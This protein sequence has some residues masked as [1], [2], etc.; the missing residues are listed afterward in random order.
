MELCVVCGRSRGLY[1]SASGETVLC[2]AHAG[3]AVV[4]LRRDRPE[5]PLVRPATTA[6]REAVL[7][8]TDAFWGEREVAAFGR[9]YDLAD[10]PAL[11]AVDGGRTVGSVSYALEGEV[12][13]LVSMQVLPRFQGRGLGRRLVEAVMEIGR[14]AEARRLQLVT[15]ND[16][17]PALALYQRLGLTITEVVPG[18]VLAHHGGHVE[19]GFAGIPVRDEIRMVCDL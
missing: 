17:L 14:Q 6:D 3:L 2:P 5:P 18:A 13:H 7:E 19:A 9:T 10:L 4:P 16:N 11:I 1:R 12:V 15:T 8:L